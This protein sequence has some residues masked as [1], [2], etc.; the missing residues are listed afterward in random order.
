MTEVL[1]HES[2]LI[3]KTQAS[4]TKT[5]GEIKMFVVETFYKVDP[6]AAV[7]HKASH[8]EFV[9]KYIRNGI[10]LYAGP[11]QDDTGGIIVMNGSSSDEVARIMNEDSFVS[12]GIVGMKISEF[13]ALFSSQKAGS[14]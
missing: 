9:E 14:Q 13:N 7:P 12:E 5:K 3:R 2:E 4:T 6:A 8:K 1:P 10:F 11:K